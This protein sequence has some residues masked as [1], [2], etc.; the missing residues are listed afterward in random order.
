MLKIK[1]HY[2]ADLL[3]MDVKPNK[4][5][6]PLFTNVGWVTGFLDTLFTVNS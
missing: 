6:L 3:G 1:T 2:F 4:L 5:T